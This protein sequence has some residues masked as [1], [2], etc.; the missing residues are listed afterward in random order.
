MVPKSHCQGIRKSKFVGMGILDDFSGEWVSGDVSAGDVLIFTNLTVHKSLL[1][2][3][4]KLRQSFDARYQAASQ[5]V[6]QVTITP[7]PDS[8][9]ADWESVYAN[10]NSEDMQFY[11]REFD[12]KIVPFGKKHFEIDYPLAFQIAKSGDLSMRES[13]LRL[14]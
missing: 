1:N 7:G 14:I 10:W 6:T 4:N 3:T 5:P 13:L 9:C 12:L 11:W 8:G 2:Q